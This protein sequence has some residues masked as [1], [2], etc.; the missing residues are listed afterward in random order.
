MN[1]KQPF[2]IIGSVA[3]KH[4]FP[5]FRQPN[6]FDIVTPI[7]SSCIKTN[8]FVDIQSHRLFDLIVDAS[9]NKTFADPDVLLT[10]KL[11][12]VHYDTVFFSKS[13][14]DIIFY[15]KHGCQVIEPLYKE[16][17]VLWNEIRPSKVKL[18]GVRVDEF[19]TSTVTRKYDHEWLHELVA[20]NARPLH[21]RIRPD[22]TSVHC[23]YD[24]YMQLSKQQQ[25]ELALEELMVI[26]IER[27]KLT[28]K[29]TFIDIIQ[30]MTNA[31]RLLITSISRG[32]FS[33]YYAENYYSIM[34]TSK[35]L[36]IN[37]IKNVL[38]QLAVV[39]SQSK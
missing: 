4:W 21:E 14:N 29:S 9:D 32:W 2:I 15:Q 20:F 18:K 22:L 1:S 35:A 37:R 16:L 10:L 7:D 12:H 25:A 26:A 30:A 6:D 23:D 8:K 31:I 34:T 19:F 28:N 13:I 5:D 17:A 27:G 11:S 33:R 39:D 24:M 38:D 36:L 3:A